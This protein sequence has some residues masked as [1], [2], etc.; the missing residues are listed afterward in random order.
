MIKFKPCIFYLLVFLLSTDIAFSFEGKVVSVT[1]GDTIKVL[2]ENKELIKIRLA[3]I[4]TPEKKQP[5]GRKAK[6]ALSG[7]LNQ[8]TVSVKP[9]TKDRYG[10]TIAHIYSDG[11]NINREMVKTGNA[12]VYRKY[13]KDRTLLDD[14]DYARKHK[15]GLW[16]LPESQRVPPWKWRKQRR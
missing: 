5:W 13:M 11:V 7:F 14:E 6:K 4:D 12:W 9:V 2:T 10:R 1:D 8:K 3:E 15:L 16:G